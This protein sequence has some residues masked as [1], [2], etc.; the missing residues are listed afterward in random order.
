M[1]ASQG[2]E[3]QTTQKIIDRQENILQTIRFILQLQMLL[4]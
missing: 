4:E 2:H 1:L 3:K